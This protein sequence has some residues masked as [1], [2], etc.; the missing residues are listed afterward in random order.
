MAQ[1]VSKQAFLGLGLE[2]F[3]YV[4][5]RSYKESESLKKFR[6]H[7]GV[8]PR[9]CRDVWRALL[10]CRSLPEDANPKHLLLAI[11]FLFEYPKENNETSRFGMSAK[12]ARKWRKLYISKISSL[13]S[14]FVSVS[15]W[16]FL[17]CKTC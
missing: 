13:F 5:W 6:K 16:Q 9:T 8:S 10:N 15:E 11:F 3:G 17:I 12:T 14:V 2:I 4:R 7:F 1:A